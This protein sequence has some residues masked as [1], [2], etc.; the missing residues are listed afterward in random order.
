MSLV[1]LVAPAFFP[2][3]IGCA[4][5]CFRSALPATYAAESACAWRRRLV[6][7]Q[8]HTPPPP[9]DTATTRTSISGGPSS[10]VVTIALLP[11]ASRLGTTWGESVVAGDHAAVRRSTP[12]PW[13]AAVIHYNDED[14]VRAH[15]TYV[16]GAIAPLEALVGDGSIGVS[17]SATAATSC[18]GCAGYRTCGRRRRRPLPHRDPQRH[19]GPLRDV[20]SVDGLDVIDGKPA[21][22]ERRGYLVDPTAPGHRFGLPPTESEVAA[23]RFGKVAASYAARTSGD[24]NVGVIGIAVFA[25]RGAV[26]SPAELGRRDQADPFP[27]RGYATP[28]R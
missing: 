8:P 2:S 1:R 14:G 20:A 6:V 10:E 22:P 3:L 19:L 17:W 25:E 15:A 12:Q 27:A 24:N 28:P 21:A 16:G 11:T 7:V 26:W 4:G 5:G 18:P 23:F 13:A 9:P